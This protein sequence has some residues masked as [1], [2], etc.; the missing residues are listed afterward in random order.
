MPDLDLFR[1]L[2]LQDYNTRI[3]VGGVTVLGLASGV[4]GSFMLLRKRSLLG[5][6]ISHATLPGIACAFLVLGALG[7][8]GKNLPGLLLGATLSGGLGV[9]AILLLVHW[10]RLKEDAAL[11]IVLSV[12]FGLGVCLLRIIQKLETGSAAGLE[13]FIYGKT[14]SM[15][16]SDAQLILASSLVIAGT[17]GLL[18]KEF[19]L[20]CFDT[21]YAGAQGWPIVALD[22][23]LM[24]LVVGV[25]VVGLQ[26]VGL[27]LM[28]ALLI[29]PA[30]AARFWTEHLPTMVVGAAVLGAVSSLVGALLSALL[31]DTPAGA[32]IVLVASGFFLVSL[33]AGP[34]RGVVGRAWRQS[35]LRRKIARQHLLRAVYEL[36]EMANHPPSVR[37]NELLARR[38]WSPRQLAQTISAAERAGLV[39][40][41]EPNA[42]RLTE[43]GRRHAARVTRNHRLW[44]LYLIEHADIAPSHVDRDADQIEHVLAPEM[45]QKLEA[46]L[47]HQDR[48]RQPPASPHA[49]EER[50]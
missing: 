48:D 31:P 39:V 43:P 41:T 36:S 33:L 34:A 23:T 3:V 18:F 25:T 20:L 19:T 42:I 10:T 45:I 2:T 49:L 47:L 1:V 50:P 7:L 28:V 24:V 29:I 17:C 14:A 21:Q 26:A 32:V 38:S 22:I 4:I 44:E 27:I 5:D 35:E 15:I 12:F 40:P 9:G 13:S 30:A 16:A 8:D 6:A 37:R 46:L 11:G